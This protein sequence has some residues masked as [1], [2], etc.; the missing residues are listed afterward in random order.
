M[1]ILRQSLCAT[2]RGNECPRD[3]LHH[4]QDTARECLLLLPQQVLRAVP[5]LPECCAGDV[6]QSVQ[7]P[8]AHLGGGWRTLTNSPCG[9]AP[10]SL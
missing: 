9:M 1:L 5:D 2:E 10:P 3:C 8:C 7:S 6:A 4:I